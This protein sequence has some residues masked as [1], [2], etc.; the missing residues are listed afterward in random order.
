[1]ARGVEVATIRVTKEQ[2]LDTQY[3]LAKDTPVDV[4]TARSNWRISTNRHPH[5][6]RIKAYSPYL[7]RHKK[8]YGTG[9]NKSET[10]NLNA[11]RQ[12]GETR[13]KAYKYGTIYITNNVPYI[14]PLN[15]GHSRQTASG[16]VQRA[17]LA[18]V[19]KTKFKI[20]GIF[21]D[22]FSK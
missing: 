13:L 17:V 22:E 15:R 11:V 2:A 1:M 18:A 14:G 8:P 7:S 19:L 3:L 21:E 5:V 20:K 4:A 6:G 16:F 10:V 9:G 12:Q